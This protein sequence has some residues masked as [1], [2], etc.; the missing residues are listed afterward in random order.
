M[1]NYPVLKFKLNPGLDAKI[2]AQFL[3]HQ[4][5]GIDFGKNIL[6]NHPELVSALKLEGEKRVRV[7]RDYLE[8]FYQQ[9]R[10]ELGKTLDRFR[11]EW[12]VAQQDFF[13]TTRAVFEDHSWPSGMYICFLSIFNCNPRFLDTKTFQAYYRNRVGILHNIAHE[14]LHFIFYDWLEKNKP[15]FIKKVGDKRIWVL[16]EIFDVLAFEQPEYSLFRSK[17]PGG[18]PDIQPLAKQIQKRLKE[19]S[20]TIHNFLNEAKKFYKEKRKFYLEKI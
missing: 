4:K 14:M 19:K 11:A 18:Y 6:K 7:V 10:G 2:G 8:G 1:S 15:D 9:H 20:F 5:A 13:E 3:T 17:I 12:S 16:S